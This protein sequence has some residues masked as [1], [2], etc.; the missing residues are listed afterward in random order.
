MEVFGVGLAGAVGAE[1]RSVVA[2][3]VE[4][5]E[6]FGEVVGFAG[7]RGKLEVGDHVGVD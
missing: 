5:E 7:A 4:A 6:V 1:E 2:V 3:G